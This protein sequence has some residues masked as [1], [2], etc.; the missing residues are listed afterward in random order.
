MGGGVEAVAG[1]IEAGLEPRARVFLRL[2]EQ[3]CAGHDPARIARNCAALR[4]TILDQCVSGAL[5]PV[6]ARSLCRMVDGVQGAALAREARSEETN[7]F[8]DHFVGIVGHDLRNPLTAIVTSAQ[9]LLR[10]GG[11]DP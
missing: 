10:H 7:G 9:L 1:S 2:A 6:A 11:L 4:Q 5:T 3:A 8:R